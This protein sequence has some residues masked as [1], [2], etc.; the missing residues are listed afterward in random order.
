ML[1]YRD[2]DRIKQTNAFLRPQTVFA[3]SAMSDD[4]SLP[5]ISTDEAASVPVFNCHVILSPATD[6]G[7]I[8]GRAANLPEISASGPTE[9]DVLRSVMQQFKTRVK[10]SMDAGQ[11]VSF[12][13]PPQTPGQGEVERFI[14]VH[15]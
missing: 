6:D 3:M 12:L 2:T 8:V 7:K 13:D 11:P 10:E 1:F 4:S 5:L 15:L 14:P 9:R